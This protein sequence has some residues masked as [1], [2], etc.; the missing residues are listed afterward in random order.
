MQAIF[1]GGLHPTLR[2][3]VWTFLL[4]SYD[5]SWSSEQ[6]QEHRHRREEDYEKIKQRRNDMSKDEEADFWR[7]V[8]CTV[9][10]DVVRTDRSL[11]L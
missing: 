7:S 4:H 2:Q 5:W 9:E 10:K 8:Q 11:H 1:F 3:E 6:R